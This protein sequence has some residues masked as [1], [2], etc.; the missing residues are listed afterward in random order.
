MINNDPFI[1]LRVHTAYSLCEG[2]V[3]I[4]DLIETCEREIFPAVAITDT[5]N[6]FGIMEFSTKCAD[7]GIQPII[8][9]TLDI[10]FENTTAP[11]PLIVQ[12]EEG[13]CCLMKLM[14]AF[15]FKN[16]GFITLKDLEQYYHDIICLS[17]GVSGVAGKLISEKN[18]DDAKR[19]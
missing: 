8:G 14:T 7:H 10:K 12:T 11:I 2:A 6:M 3:K 13:Y 16:K 1:H 19:Y 5:N 4:P 9:T 17:G 15:Y 18:T